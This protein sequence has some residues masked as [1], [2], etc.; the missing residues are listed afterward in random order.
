M[1][2]KLRRTPI[3]LK[4]I[5]RDFADGPQAVSLKSLSPADIEGMTKDLNDY[6]LFFY[7]MGR[8]L[9]SLDDDIVRLRKMITAADK[10][11]SAFV[12]YYG[13]YPFLEAWDRLNGRPKEPASM[14]HLNAMYGA[15]PP[16]KGVELL[17]LAGTSVPSCDA[18]RAVSA[19]F[20]G[21]AL[22]KQLAAS[23]LDERAKKQQAD[24]GALSSEELRRRL[25][26]TWIASLY[27]KYT[28]KHPVATRDSEWCAFLAAILA[29]FGGR[30]ELTVDAAYAAWRTTTKWLRNM[31]TEYPWLLSD[32]G[33]RK[34]KN[35]TRV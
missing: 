35:K 6:A 23:E 26:I 30:D 29:A 7:S 20:D 10:L 19:A 28:R 4:S 3:D 2:T 17:H 13:T 25:A 27:H 31:G 34:R 21:I 5:V 9:P 1:S 22:I 11:K 18:L 14:E 32:E 16:D 24:S 12:S 15:S 33:K 8:G